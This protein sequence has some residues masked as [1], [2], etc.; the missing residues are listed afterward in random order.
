MIY[1]GKKISTK[2][3]N[4]DLAQSKMLQENEIEKLKIVLNE[5]LPAPTKIDEEKI[6]SFKNHKV[7]LGY[8]NAYFNHCPIILSPNVIWQLILNNFSFASYKRIPYINFFFIGNFPIL[9]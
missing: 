3:T 5:N 8:L 9:Q 6:K 2:E 4:H 7:L 1:L